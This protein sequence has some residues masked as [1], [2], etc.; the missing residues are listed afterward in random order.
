MWAVTASVAAVAVLFA[1]SVLVGRRRR[2][3]RAVLFATTLEAL[4]PLLASP[5]QSAATTPRDEASRHERADAIREANEQAETALSELDRI[6]RSETAAAALALRDHVRELA[7]LFEARVHDE[8]DPYL[9]DV[10]ITER[11]ERVRAA[12][13]R[14]AKAVGG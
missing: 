3:R 6:S 12:R 5:A 1:I 7:R 11:Q 14:L 4:D 9:L 8:G 2:R 13:E 10:R